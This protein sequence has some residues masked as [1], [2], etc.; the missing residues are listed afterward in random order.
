MGEKNLDEKVIIVTVK[1]FTESRG[2]F[3]HLKKR[4]GDNEGTREREVEWH[5]YMCEYEY[6]HRELYT[7]MRV[8]KT[9]GDSKANEKTRLSP[10]HQPITRAVS[11]SEQNNL[12]TCTHSERWRWGG[13]T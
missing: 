6:T 2:S 11:Q 1:V 10:L 3:H 13:G 5:T 7:H 8:S 12:T 9:H 4:R